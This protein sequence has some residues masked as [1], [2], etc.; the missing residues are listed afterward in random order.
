MPVAEVVYVYGTLRP[1]EPGTVQIPGTPYDLGWFPGII[2]GGENFVTR[3]RIEVEDLDAVDAYEGYNPKFTIESLYIRRPILD[4][5]IYEYN[6][7]FNPQRLVACG[8]WFI[9]TQQERGQNG[10]RFR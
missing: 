6:Q 7:E 10:G 1:G 5:W 9:Y 8:D 4:G 3:E 2:L